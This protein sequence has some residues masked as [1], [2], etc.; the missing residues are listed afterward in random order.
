M[1]ADPAGPAPADPR[2]PAARRGG[3][4]LSWPW[5]ILPWMPGGPAHL[6]P[7]TADQAPVLAGF[8]KALHQPAPT[9]APHNPHRGV[10]LNDRLDYLTPRIDR[11]AAET[12]LITPRIREVWARALAAPSTSRRPGCTA[13]PTPATCCRRTAS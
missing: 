5:S 11:L 3:R 6:D 12:N 4:G 2:A 1:A 13:T 7:L 10:P 8:L 9:D